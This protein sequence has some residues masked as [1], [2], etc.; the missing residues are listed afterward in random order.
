MMNVVNNKLILPL[1]ILSIEGIYTPEH[2]YRNDLSYFIK[3]RYKKNTYT[4]LEEN[5]NKEIII[6]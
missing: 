4:I 2:E 1:N 5:N 3:Y 6:P